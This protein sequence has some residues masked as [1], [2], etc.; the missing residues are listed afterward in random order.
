MLLPPLLWECIQTLDSFYHQEDKAKC[1][2]ILDSYY[3]QEDKTED[4]M[5]MSPS[6]T[7]FV[8]IKSSLPEDSYYVIHKS[9]YP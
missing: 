4:T 7:I 1:V 9:Y 2:Q 5:H 8:I 6:K 3:H